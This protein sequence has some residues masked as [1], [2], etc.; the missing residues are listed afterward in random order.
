MAVPDTGQGTAR[1]LY[2]AATGGTGKPF[3]LDAEVAEN[4]AAAC[5]K[6]VEDLRRAMTT[7]HLVTEVTGFP[8]LPTGHGLTRGFRDKGR[9]YLDTLAAFQ[10]TALLFKAAY[11]AAG[12]RFADAEAAHRAA[13][14]VVTAHL[15]AR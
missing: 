10:E 5:D 15:E 12:K 1:L 4:L 8:N 7:G 3:E 11:L 13:L 2:A 6:L 14:A 9:Q